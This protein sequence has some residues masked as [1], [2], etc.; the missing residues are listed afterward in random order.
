M[1]PYVYVAD[2]PI[3]LIDPDGKKIVDATG[4]EITY[5]EKSGWSKNATPSVRRIGEA[6]MITPKGTE[7]FN[8]LSDANYNV[9]MSLNSGKSTGGEIGS[10]SP[11]YDKNGNQ[12]KASIVIYEG[13][14]TEYRQNLEDTKSAIGRGANVSIIDQGS[15]ARLEN[16]NMPESNDEVIGQVGVHEAEHATN[17]NAQAKFNSNKEFGPDSREGLARGAEVKAIEQTSDNR[18]K[19]LK[20]IELK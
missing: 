6:M 5:S 16:G 19:L 8:K 1:S 2:N 11:T 14:V 3:R 18:Y 7:M 12:T 15:K 17:K 10:M 9:T 13:S 20:P 4:K